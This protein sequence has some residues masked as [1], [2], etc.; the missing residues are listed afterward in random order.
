MFAHRLFIYFGNHIL[1]K[2][3]VLGIFTKI[4]HE[5]CILMGYGVASYPRRFNSEL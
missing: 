4:K 5:V 3:T 2:M 1:V